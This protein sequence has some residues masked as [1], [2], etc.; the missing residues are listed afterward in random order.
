MS[1]TVC[2]EIDID[3]EF[4]ID[5]E[6]VIFVAYIEHVYVSK[7]MQILQNWIKYLKYVSF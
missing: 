2:I 7:A 1:V 6:K 4:D 3:I 5:I